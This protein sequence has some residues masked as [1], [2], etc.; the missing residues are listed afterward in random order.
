M[1]GRIFKYAKY[2]AYHEGILTSRVNPP[3]SLTLLPESE[4]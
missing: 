1:K 4:K 2:K 3:L